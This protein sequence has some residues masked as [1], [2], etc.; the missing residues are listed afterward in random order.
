[1][2]LINPEWFGLVS[3]TVDSDDNKDSRKK[4]QRKLQIRDS[5]IRDKPPESPLFDQR[6]KN[7]K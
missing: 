1:M 5:E 3:A 6:S 4:V 2:G 7:G